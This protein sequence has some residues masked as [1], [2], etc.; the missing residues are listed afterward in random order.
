LTGAYH[1]ADF[2]VIVE[3]II[4][5]YLNT[6]LD[7]AIRNLTSTEISDTEMQIANDAGIESAIFFVE[8]G[9]TLK[10]LGISIQL[11]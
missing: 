9:I 11:P 2:D 4:F 3:H 8:L 7:N 5:G 6:K 1:A 10:A